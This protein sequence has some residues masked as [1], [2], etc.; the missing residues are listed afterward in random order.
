MEKTICTVAIK[1]KSYLSI[2]K[3]MLYRKNE[4][5]LVFF[6]PNIANNIIQLYSNKKKHHI[7]ISTRAYVRPDSFHNGSID[8]SPTFKFNSI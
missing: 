5:K 7:Y 2:G 6:C 4:N 8:Q 3:K 1:S